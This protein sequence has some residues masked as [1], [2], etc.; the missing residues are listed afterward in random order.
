MPRRCPSFACIAS[1]AFTLLEFL[2]VLVVIA[3]AST[4][5][6]P[7]LFQGEQEAVREA[8]QRVAAALNAAR[9]AAVMSRRV[10]GVAANGGV[11]EFFERDRDDPRRWSALR[12][13]DLAPPRL[14]AGVN[15]RIAIAEGERAV[16]APGGV[17]APFAVLV[18]AGS[19]Q[20]RVTVDALGNVRECEAP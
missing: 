3:I 19:R 11:L 8:A 17:A 9:D 18:E 4:L 15:L 2:L 16:F 14:A 7:K 5:A 6:V 20:R 10:I 13:A 1:P 12:R